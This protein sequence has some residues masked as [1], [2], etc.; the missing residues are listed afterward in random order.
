MCAAAPRPRVRGRRPRP[1]DPVHRSRMRDAFLAA[2]RDAHAE[3]ARARRRPTSTA[4]APTSSPRSSG[5]SPRPRAGTC[6]IFGDRA[7]LLRR[8]RAR[9]PDRVARRAACGSAAGSTSR[10]PTPTARRSSAS[11]TSGAG[12]RR[13]TTR[14]S[15]R[16]CALAV[17]RLTRW[18][19]DDPLRVDVGRP[20]ARHRART[21]RRRRRR[22]AASCVRGSRSGSQVVRDARRRRHRVRPA[23]TA[24]RAASSSACPEHP[25]GAHFGRRR[26]ALPGIVTLTPTSL[27]TWRRC[28]RDVAR[29]STC[30][31]VPASDGDPSPSHGQQLHDMLGLVHEQGR[32]ATTRTS[33]TCSPRTACRDDDA[34]RGPRS[35]TTCAGAPRLRSRSATRSRAARFHR[36]R[37]RRSWRPRGSTPRG[38]TTACSTRATT[39]PAACG[40]SEVSPRRAGA[41][42]GVRA[43]AAWPRQRG[44]RLRIAF[45]HL[46]SEV[47]DDPAPFEPDA[48]DLASIEEELR[49][50]RRGDPRREQFG[51][52]ADARR[53]RALPVPLDLPRVG[54]AERAGVAGGRSRG[55]RP[56]S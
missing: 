21:G 40:P 10:S 56:T 54:R 50:D 19:G 2:A 22:A 11:S 31:Q 30:Y 23:T 24:A 49:L 37:C 7:V 17:L 55:R 38:C 14:S 33:T 12:A 15:S 43:R 45:E 6:E 3:L 28:P 34:H 27:D 47:V 29:R 1:H 13:S 32:A 4:S 53:V 42:P 51:G 39:R 35:R 46:A 8:P 16:R 26:D 48:D 20:R 44:L 9:H 25:T 18:C 41:P 5:C 36:S 52:V